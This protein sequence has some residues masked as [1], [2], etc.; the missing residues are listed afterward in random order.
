VKENGVED[1][2]SKGRTWILVVA[3]LAI[4]GAGLRE[5]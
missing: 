3:S 1:L 4:P 5:R 2:A